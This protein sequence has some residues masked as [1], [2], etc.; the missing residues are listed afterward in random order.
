VICEYNQELNLILQQ[1]GADS[2]Q[3]GVSAD[4]NAL[5]GGAPAIFKEKLA[6]TDILDLGLLLLSCLL[7]VVCTS[8]VFLV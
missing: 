1:K 2:S 7:K 8:N 3:I 5:L 4:N 6:I